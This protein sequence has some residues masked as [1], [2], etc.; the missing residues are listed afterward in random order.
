MTQ[1]AFLPRN[2]RTASAPKP[3]M[4]R[5]V[6]L[7]A[8]FAAASEWAIMGTPQ[9]GWSTLGRSE[10]MRVPFPA[11]R[12]MAVIFIGIS[13]GLLRNSMNFPGSKRQENGIYSR[14]LT[15]HPLT[16]RACA[17]SGTARGPIWEKKAPLAGG[18]FRLGRL[19]SNQD[20]QLHRLTCCQ[21]TT[22]Q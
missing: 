14:L 19:D 18:K 22:P 4:T 7:L 8:A 10:F 15:R 5:G 3:M 9:T 11:A 13:Y 2:S 6:S 21:C 12:I 20:H 1:R 16:K 17:A